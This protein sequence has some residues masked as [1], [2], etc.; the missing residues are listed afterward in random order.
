M[1]RWACADIA[2]QLHARFH[3]VCELAKRFRID[4]PV[5]AVVRLCKAWVILP[6]KI[7]AVYDHAAKLHGV[8]VHIF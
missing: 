8:S 4:Y 7:S 1:G 2:H 3:D 5:I 6:V